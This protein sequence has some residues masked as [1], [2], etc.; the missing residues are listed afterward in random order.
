[1]IVASLDHHQ[2]SPVSGSLFLMSPH[3]LNCFKFA[4]LYHFVRA[5]YD[6][7]LQRII[8]IAKIHPNI[9]KQYPEVI[10]EFKELARNNFTF[11]PS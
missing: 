4:I 6:P 5:S 2:L 9:Y 8:N 10:E 11:M 1:M 7:S 3:V